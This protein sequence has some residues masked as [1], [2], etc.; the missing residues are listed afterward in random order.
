[1]RMRALMYNPIPQPAPCAVCGRDFIPTLCQRHC[2]HD[3]C[4]EAGCEN[5]K[6]PTRSLASRVRKC[7]A[8]GMRADQKRFEAFAPCD[9]NCRRYFWATP[10]QWNSGYRR[11]WHCW[12][13]FGVNDWDRAQHRPAAKP[14]VHIKYC[15]LQCYYH[16]TKGHDARKSAGE[17]TRNKRYW[18]KRTQGGSKSASLT[19]MRRLREQAAPAVELGLSSYPPE[20]QEEY[21]AFKARLQ[22]RYAD[23]QSDS[24][25]NG[26]PPN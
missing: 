2:V 20:M 14:R 16:S 10:S 26:T 3:C 21:L 11:G 25:E 9:E 6:P 13:V 22:T 5:A 18:N 23:S 1:M 19:E 24:P 17:N 4:R 15:S 7:V 8:C 12:G